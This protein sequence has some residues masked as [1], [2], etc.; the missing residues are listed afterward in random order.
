MSQQFPIDMGDRDLEEIAAL[1]ESSGR[2]RVLRRLA[3]PAPAPVPADL[4]RRG[5]FVDVETTGLDAGKDTVIELAMVP[6]SYGLDGQIYAVGEAFDRLREPGCPIP[7]EVTAITGLT[8]DM[9]A[10]HSIDPAEVAAFAAS[11]ALVVAHSAAFDRRVLERFS[12]VFRTKPWACSMSQV[13]WAEEGFEG[14]KLVYL[15]AG[16]GFFYD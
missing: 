11:A 5:L 15:A 2:F 12:D 1:L 10:G 4:F 9:V 8:D 3:E 6:F 13:A 7:P 14:Q 16:A